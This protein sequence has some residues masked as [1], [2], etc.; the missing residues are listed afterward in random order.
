MDRRSPIEDG[1]LF[2]EGFAAGEPFIQH[3]FQLH[4]LTP[5]QAD[6]EGLRIDR[7]DFGLCLFDDLIRKWTRGN[8][9]SGRTVFHVPGIEHIGF[10]GGILMV[11]AVLHRSPVPAQVS[12]ANGGR[13]SGCGCCV[14]T[15]SGF[16]VG[17]AAALPSK[18]FERGVA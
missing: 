4:A 14:A 5:L 16:P 15:A 17:S 12:A 9:A 8:H 6:V 10:N 2:R 11:C 13:L 7:L 18:D 1:Q 3:G